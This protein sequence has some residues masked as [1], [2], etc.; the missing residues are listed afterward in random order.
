ML[1]LDLHVHTFYS[2]DALTSPGEAV[3]WAR[4]AG[5]DGLAITDHDTLVGAERTARLAG[6]RGLLVVPGMEVETRGGHLLLLCPSEPVRSGTS[7]AEAIDMARDVGALVVLAH[8]YSLLA[9]K[10]W[11]AAELRRLDAVEVINARELLFGFSCRM[12]RKLAL[13]LGKP[14]TGGSDAHVPEAIGSAYTLVKADGD[15]DDV[16]EAIRKGRIRP[17]GRRTSFKNLLKKWAYCAL[18]LRA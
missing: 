6:K 11:R 4:R 14:M 9:P 12:A 7:L 10:G 16:L 15:V 3:A 5:L 17:F 1:K 8:P 13:A 2:G 18:P